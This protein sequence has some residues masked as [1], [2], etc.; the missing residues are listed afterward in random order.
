MAG[1]CR[2]GLGYEE[3]GQAGSQVA[4]LWLTGSITTQSDI[5]VGGN[6][7]GT[8][9]GTIARI[10]D[11][12]GLIRSN[13]LESGAYTRDT[14][15]YGGVIQ[16]GGVTLSDGSEATITFSK[17]YTNGSYAIFFSPAAVSTDPGVP[18]FTSGALRGS[19]CEVIWA[20]STSY[21]W[22]AIGEMV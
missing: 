2:D 8:Y 1:G 7:S 16:A 12:N 19:G 14:A 15:T 20:A 22:L 3:V 5:L 10:N 6:I 11:T 4:N 17:P 18:A 13:Y 9:S 21:N